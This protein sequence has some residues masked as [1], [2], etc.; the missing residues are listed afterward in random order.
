MEDKT[1]KWDWHPCVSVGPLTFGESISPLIEKFDLQ[2]LDT[3]QAASGHIPY[4][5]PNCETRIYANEDGEIENVGCFDNLY[6]Q[7]QNLFGLTLDEIRALLGPEEE[8][9]ETVLFDF[10]GNEFEKFPVDYYE[11][12][13]QFWFR[14]GV[15]ESVMVFDPSDDE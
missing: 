4:D 7:G 10:P 12:G 2:E 11:L 8:I 14:D 5:F 15:V 13:A 1:M 9:G 6:Y 3:D